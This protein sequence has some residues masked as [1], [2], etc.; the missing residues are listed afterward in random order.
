MTFVKFLNKFLN[1]KEKETKHV[2]VSVWTNTA[3]SEIEMKFR[4][5][6]IG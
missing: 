5:S 6:T 1:K 2:T 3:E 4:T